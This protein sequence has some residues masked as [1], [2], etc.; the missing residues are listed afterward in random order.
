[1]IGTENGGRSVPVAENPFRS[2]T[3]VRADP[4]SMSAIPT[5]LAEP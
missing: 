3:S 1:M 2:S 5:L 4:D